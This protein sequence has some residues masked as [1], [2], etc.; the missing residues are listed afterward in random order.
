MLIIK[1]PYCGDREETE[2]SYGGENK[3]RP[4]DP[5]SLSDKEWAEYLFFKKN[6]VVW[7]NELWNHSHGCRRWFSIERH[8]VTNEI[9]QSTPSQLSM[10]ENI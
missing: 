3:K 10:E 5:Y 2:F 8:T 9:K 1:C 6:T 4:A 7:H